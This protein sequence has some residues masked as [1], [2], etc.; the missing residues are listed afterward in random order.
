MYLWMK[1]VVWGKSSSVMLSYRNPRA[2]CASTRAKK[3]KGTPNEENGD[4]TTKKNFL[5]RSSTTML[6][7]TL[8]IGT[9]RTRVSRL[10]ISTGERN[11]SVDTRS[12]ES[13]SARR[14]RGRLS[15]C[16]RASFPL[17]RLSWWSRWRRHP[18]C[19]R[20]EKEEVANK[21]NR[22]ISDEWRPV[23]RMKWDGIWKR[24]FPKPKGRKKFAF[25][26]DVALLL[27]LLLLLLL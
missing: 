4:E 11:S 26:Y 16:Q 27:L 19:L 22:F 2:K 6:S 24:R 3:Q 25:Y 12:E 18:W 21:N 5:T 20:H 9:S 8:R 14:N 13:T 1:V 10:R 15:R 23:E 17:W 7:R